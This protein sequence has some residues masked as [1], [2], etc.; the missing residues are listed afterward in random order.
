MNLSLLSFLALLPILVVAVLLVAFRVSARIAM[1]V[2]F[3][4]TAVVAFFFWEFP[5]RYISAS[6]IQGMFITFDILYIIFGAILLLSL[7]NY[8]GASNDPVI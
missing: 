6:V 3:L 1:P 5:L 8:S 7:L 4:L 2:G